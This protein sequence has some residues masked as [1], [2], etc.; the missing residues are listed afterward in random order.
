[1]NLTL[2]CGDTSVNITAPKIQNNTEGKK[3]LEIYPDYKFYEL[4][5]FNFSTT[6][7]LPK[8]ISVIPIIGGSEDDFTVNKTL[9]NVTSNLTDPI[10]K[11]YIP[12]INNYT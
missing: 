3:F 4:D 2:Y 9:V 5:H 6:Q 7:C 10:I 12:P 11:V 1:M 8:N